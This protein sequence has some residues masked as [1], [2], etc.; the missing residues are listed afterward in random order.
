MNKPT[1]STQTYNKVNNKKFVD[2]FISVEK[3]LYDTPLI[4]GKFF[5][6]LLM[7]VTK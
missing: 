6:K 7:T 1:I 3:W 4:P 2:N 5:R